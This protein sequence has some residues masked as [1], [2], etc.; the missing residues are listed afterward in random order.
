MICFSLPPDPAELDGILQEIPNAPAVFLL[1]PA[2][3]TPYLAR[4]NVLRRRLLR[5]LGT[6]QKPSKALNLRGTILRVEY[7]LTGSALESHFVLTEQARLH[8]GANY[9]KEI[10]LRM[11]PYVKLI[12]TNEFPRTQVANRLGRAK[13]VYFGPFRTRSTAARFES[14]FLDLFQLRRCQEDLVPALEHPGC[15]YGEMARCL[16]PCQLVVG[17]A[18]YRTE[19]QRVGEFLHTAGHSLLDTAASARDRLSEEMDFE[20][21]AR[22][23]QRFEKVQAVLALTDEMVRDVSALHACTVTRS[24]S[25]GTV[26][27]GWLRGGYW[28]GFRQLPLQIGEG[29]AMS[30]DTRVRELAA[31]IPA[32]MGTPQER[33]EKLAILARWFYSSWRDGEMILFDTWEKQPIRKLV[34][35]VSRVAQSKPK[36]FKPK[37]SKSESNTGGGHAA[38][39]PDGDAPLPGSDSGR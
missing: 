6:A 27:L 2:E 10:R 4:T 22:M 35:A 16:R 38:G 12:L 3:G 14:E 20:G 29:T 34:N 25:A 39:V 8:L 33:E 11:P 9:R 24:A 32:A 5:L 17:V 19:A 7:H 31:S 37:L 1:W 21:A 30:L 23:H 26:E 18:E 13:A 36:S 28:Q 15:I